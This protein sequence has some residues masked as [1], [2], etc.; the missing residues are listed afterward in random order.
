MSIFEF[1][2]KDWRKIPQNFRFFILSGVLMVTI[3]LATDHWGQ[4]PNYKYLGMSRY[5]FFNIGIFL[6]LVGIVSIL[7]KQAALVWRVGKFRR[8]YPISKLNIGFY[9]V[10]F[11]G[12]LY[13]FDK[14]NKKTY[15]VHPGGTARDLSFEANGTSHPKGFDQAM[16]EKDTIGTSGE[17]VYFKIADYTFS[18]RINTRD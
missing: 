7:L 6:I 13:L 4:V 9:L 14:E 10:W 15:H 12:R 16:S 11:E 8:R 5:F 17:T 18:G 3:V 2:S 1:V